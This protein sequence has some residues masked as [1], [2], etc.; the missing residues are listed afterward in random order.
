MHTKM[1]EKQELW[2]KWIALLIMVMVSITFLN[3]PGTGDMNYWNTWLDYA[4]QYGLREGFRMQMDVAPPF[5]LILQIAMQRI[6]S[7]LSNFAV[8]RLANTF[9]LFLS[10]LVIHL[11][12]KDAK[13]T[14]LSFWGLILSANLGYLDIELVPFIILA[15]YCLSKEKYVL[16]SIF[17]SVVCLIKF[18]PLIIMPFIVIYFVDVL[19]AEGKKFKP[20]IRIKNMMQMSIP[21]I[22]IG[23]GVL[24]IY[25]KELINTLYRALFSNG[26]NAISPNGLNLGWVIQYWIEKYHADLFGPLDNGRIWIIWGAPSSY[27]SFRY[28]FVLIY[29]ATAII[30]LL[31]R[32]KDYALLLK[33]SLVGYTAYF[34]YKC[35]VHENHLFV[36]MLLMMLLY[37][38]EPSKNNYYRMIM[39]NVIFNI[40]LFVFY[41]IRFGRVIDGVL[42]PTLILAI[43]NVIYLSITMIWLIYEVLHPCDQEQPDTEKQYV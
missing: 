35:G 13:V 12:Y 3:S 19:D 15:F 28:I 10:A 36:A 42:D 24:L 11:L 16:S 4:R 38:E 37:I 39:Y 18:Q 41:V 22:L 23:G 34:V 1:S 8:L 31:H 32:K 26:G 17:F 25:G 43:F 5:G 21:A 2:W 29:A 9:Y 14:L 30:M 27:R 40:N 7:G 6:W 20:Y 33:C